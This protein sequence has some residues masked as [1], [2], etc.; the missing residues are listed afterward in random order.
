MISQLRITVPGQPRPQGSMQAMLS[1][2]TGQPLLRYSS[3][4]VEHR[5]HVVETIARQWAQR[6]ALTGAVAV[7][8]TFAFARPKSHYGTGRNAGI[9]KDSSPVWHTGT[10]DTD[11]LMRLIGDALHIAGV[12]KDDSQITLWRGNKKWTTAQSCISC[13]L[14]IS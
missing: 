11:K 8:A 6:E 10:P 2:S 12:L 3:T 9:V 7:D 14:A 5:N 1:R 13:S 4:T